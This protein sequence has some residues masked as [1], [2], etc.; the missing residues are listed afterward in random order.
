MMMLMMREAV[1]RTKEP[2]CYNNDNEKKIQFHSLDVKN[3]TR[4]YVVGCEW[5][6]KGNKVFIKTAVNWGKTKNSGLILGATILKTILPAH[7]NHCGSSPYI[8]IPYEF[9][10]LTYLIRWGGGGSHLF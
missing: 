3:K 1:W 6:G 8:P 9:M 5:V 7:N 2:C 4:R 10:V